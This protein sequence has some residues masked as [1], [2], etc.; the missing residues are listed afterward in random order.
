[1]EQMCSARTVLGALPVLYRHTVT[2]V[3]WRSV[4]LWLPFTDDKTEAQRIYLLMFIMWWSQDGKA[5][6]SDHSALAANYSVICPLHPFE[7]QKQVFHF[8]KKIWVIL[9]RLPI[10][11]VLLLWT[12]KL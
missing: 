8:T 3:R 5:G 1:M 11:E 7:K 12:L 6:L 2:I 4:P 9:E 10:A